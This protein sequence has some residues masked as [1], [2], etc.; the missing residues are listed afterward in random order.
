MFERTHLCLCDATYSYI[1]YRRR[2][3]AATGSPSLSAFSEYDHHH[4]VLDEDR[5]GCRPNGSA[6]GELV[7]LAHFLDRSL[8]EREEEHS[9]RSMSQRRI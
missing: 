8:S 6:A 2:G 7:G 4:T 1:A 3:K 9:R 5:A